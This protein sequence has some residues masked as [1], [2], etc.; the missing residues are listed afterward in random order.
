MSFSSLL[1]LEIHKDEHLNC[2]LT[3]TPLSFET[4]AYTAVK[5]SFGSSA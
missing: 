4:L 2:L 5:S 1:G 3:A